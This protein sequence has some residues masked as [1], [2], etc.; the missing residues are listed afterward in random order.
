LSSLLYCNKR[1]KG[2]KIKIAS[3]G[4]MDNGFGLWWLIGL[5]GIKIK[6]GFG[7]G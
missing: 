6:I 1:T 4:L 7:F 5:I 2:I 3:D